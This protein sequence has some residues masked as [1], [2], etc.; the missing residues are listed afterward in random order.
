MVR[1]G[2]G[3][4]MHKPKKQK[5]LA[6]EP[7]EV[8]M[9][10]L[11][12]LEAETKLAEATARHILLQAAEKEAAA[13]FILARLDKEEMERKKGAWTQAEGEVRKAGRE[14]RKARRKVQVADHRQTRVRGKIS[15]V[16]FSCKIEV[17]FP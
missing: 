3:V 11:R 5:S 14:L 4:G 17:K 15:R 9:A 10:E 1:Y 2:R 6:V 13:A 16:N 12:R 7:S 8:E